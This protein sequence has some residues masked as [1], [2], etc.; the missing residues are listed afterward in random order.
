MRNWCP[1]FGGGVDD[2]AGFGVAWGG[3]ARRFELA[4][5]ALDENHAFLATSWS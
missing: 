1:W 4:D 5:V 3:D 2:H